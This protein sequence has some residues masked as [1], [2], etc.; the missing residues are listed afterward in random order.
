VLNADALAGYGYRSLRGLS[1]RR[2]VRGTDG[3][4][5]GWNGGGGVRLREAILS[6][7]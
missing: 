2:G 4:L 7:G 3:R 5:F 6:G 1:G